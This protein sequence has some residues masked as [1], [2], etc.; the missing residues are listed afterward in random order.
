MEKHEVVIV[1]AGPGGL[2]AAQVLAE[3]RKNVLVLEKLPEE[4]LGEK[5]CHGMLPPHTMTILNIPKELTDV[6]LN[7]AV[8]YFADKSYES[9]DFKPPLCQMWLRKNFGKWLIQ[10]TRKIGVEIRSNSRVVALSKDKNYVELENGDKI[11][12][13]FLIGADGS[14]SIIR[15]TLG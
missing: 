2:K 4:K 7:G 8:V 6:L 3:N 12:Y 15:R 10:E 13:N 5:I 1:G 14:K 9:V 11:G